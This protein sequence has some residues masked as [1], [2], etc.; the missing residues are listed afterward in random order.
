MNGE[1][2][3]HNNHKKKWNKICHEKLCNNI[4]YSMKHNTMRFNLC[5]LQSHIL[6]YWIH[7]MVHEQKNASELIEW[8]L[9]WLK[10]V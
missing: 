6:I 1:Y 10:L 5:I 7:F 8:Q 4:K 2:Y 9:F 3:L